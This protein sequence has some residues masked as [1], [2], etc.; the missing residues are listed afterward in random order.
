MSLWSFALGVTVLVGSESAVELPVPETGED[1]EAT[2]LSDPE[3]I[4]SP[5]SWVN[6]EDYPASEVSKGIEG[7]TRF[8][9]QISEQGEVTSCTVTESSGSAVLD[10]TACEK[11]HSRAK[12]RPAL[13]S[14]G[15]AI[16]GR[17]RSAVR[18]ILPEPQTYRLLNFTHAVTVEADGSLKDCTVQSDEALD[19]RLRSS[20]LNTCAAG[21]RVAP[22]TDDYGNPVRKRVTLITRTTVEDLPEQ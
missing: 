10:V 1:R 15:D 4:G 22:F 9:L 21:V 16:T 8:E 11:I 17:W 3:P 2:L 19:N 7:V 18:W 12:F 14:K 6:G 5:G 13:D 20:M